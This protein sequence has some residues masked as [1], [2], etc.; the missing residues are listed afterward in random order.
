MY[1]HILVP[2]ENTA[3][4]DTIID[5]LRPLV[6]LLGAKMT[7]IHVADGYVAR[8]QESLNLQDSEEIRANGRIGETASRAGGR[9]IDVVSHL[10]WRTGAREYSRTRRRT[11]AT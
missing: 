1:K 5:H 2:L 8:H 6:K 11:A 7:L 3:V 9:G 4:D 10:A